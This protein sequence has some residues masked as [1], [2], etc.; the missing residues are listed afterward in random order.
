VESLVAPEDTLLADELGDDVC[1]DVVCVTLEELDGSTSE[2][3]VGI[4]CV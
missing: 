2:D 1:A 3:G 4:V